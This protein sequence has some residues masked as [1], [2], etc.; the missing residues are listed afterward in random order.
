MRQRV[1]GLG[2][3]VIDT[4]HALMTSARSE[5]VRYNAAKSLGEWLGLHE[6]DTTPKGNDKAELEELLAIAAKTS[7]IPQ[8]LPPPGPGGSLPLL[9][10]AIVEEGE[11]RE[12]EEKEPNENGTAT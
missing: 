10:T 12:L 4:M 11:W 9:S 3:E 1:A 8:F 2:D 5:L 6:L 7:I